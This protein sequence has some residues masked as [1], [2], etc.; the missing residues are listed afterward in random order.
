MREMRHIVTLFSKSGDFNEQWIL[1]K[2]Y[3]NTAHSLSDNDNV[4]K[5]NFHKN[6]LMNFTL[7]LRNI[8]HHQPAKWRFGKHDVQPTSIS[9]SFSQNTGENTSTELSLVIQKNTLEEQELQNIL[10]DK[11]KKQLAILR[12]SLEKI[13][14]HVII[15]LELIQ[16]IQAYVE[17]YCKSEGQYTESYDKEPNGYLLKKM[18]DFV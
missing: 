8:L 1:F 6:E 4:A 12:G 14:S 13:D 2:A 16:Q 15:V 11:S 3:L 9:F 10:G 7:V 17:Q 18:N 5:T